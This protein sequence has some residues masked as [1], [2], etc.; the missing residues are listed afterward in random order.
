[1]KRI[2]DKAHLRTNNTPL[3]IV[4]IFKYVGTNLTNQN[5]IQEEI[6]SILNAGNV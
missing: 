1:L 4:A 6:E 2:K 3:K 5:S